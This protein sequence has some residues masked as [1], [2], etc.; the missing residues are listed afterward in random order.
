MKLVEIRSD[1]QANAAARRIS[2]QRWQLAL[3]D[4]FE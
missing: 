2:R 3:L 4:W 1:D